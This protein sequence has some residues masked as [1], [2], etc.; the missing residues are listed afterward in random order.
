MQLFCA[1]P[2]IIESGPAG[3]SGCTCMRLRKAS[4]RLSQIYDHYLERHGLT[5]TQ[6][7]L[8]SNLSNLS[9]ISI[10]AL[11]EK[12]VT[13]PTTLTRNLRPLER[14]GL[15]APSPDPTDRRAR[16]LHLTDKGRATLA[17]ARPTWAEAQRHIENTVGGTEILALHTALDRMLE[18]LAP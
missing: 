5:I 17:E 16:R 10:G 3:L 1:M 7:A 12:M 4:R 13:D 11:A 15:V 2:E 8:L 14:E 6:Y 18:R 9:G